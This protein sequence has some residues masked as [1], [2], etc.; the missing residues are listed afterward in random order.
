[1]RL[2]SDSQILTLLSS[3]SAPGGPPGDQVS[4]TDPFGQGRGEAQ[5]DHVRWA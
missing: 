3:V 4:S 2:G 1:M 5:P